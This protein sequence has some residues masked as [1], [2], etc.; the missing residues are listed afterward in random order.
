M[1]KRVLEGGLGSVL[2]RNVLVDGRKINHFVQNCFVVSP[3]GHH[4]R[5]QSVHRVGITNPDSILA[6]A[7]LAFFLIQWCFLHS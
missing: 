6:V 5:E 4:V 3:V 7:M 1:E 2:L